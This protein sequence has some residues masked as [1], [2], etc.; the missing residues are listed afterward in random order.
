MVAT[1]LSATPPNAPMQ[2]TRMRFIRGSG[3]SVRV[4]GPTWGWPLTHYHSSG[5]PMH[6]QWDDAGHCPTSPGWRTGPRSRAFGRRPGHRSRFPHDA[7]DVR[8]LQLRVRG[9][10]TALVVRPMARQ[11]ASDAHCGTVVKEQDLASGVGAIAMEAAMV[12]AAQSGVGG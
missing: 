7:T 6:R 9:R 8:T 5:R 12:V 11:P 4:R 2:M 3:S 10:A 1:A